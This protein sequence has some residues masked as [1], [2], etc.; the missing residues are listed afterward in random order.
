MKA[1]E[2]EFGMPKGHIFQV[3]DLFDQRNIYKGTAILIQRYHPL[4]PIRSMSLVYPSSLSLTS[5]SLS[6]SLSL[7]AYFAFLVI[8]TLSEFR[9]T[10]S[11][12]R[13][14]STTAATGKKNKGKKN[15]ERTKEMYNFSSHR[16]S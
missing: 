6:L 7:S 12:A 13:P 16:L 11:S 4:Y 8:D 2:T 1:C 14:S 5:L 3:S 9:L 15:T 10:V